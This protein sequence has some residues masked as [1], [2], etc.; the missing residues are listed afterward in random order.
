MLEEGKSVEEAVHES[1][2]TFILYDAPLSKPLKHLNDLGFFNFSKFL[3][4]TQGVLHKNIRRSP[5][6]VLMFAPLW[7]MMGAS[8]TID[9]L[10]TPF[11]FMEL[12][13]NRMQLNPLGFIRN[14][15]TEL[16][17]IKLLD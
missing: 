16:P 12:L 14:G 8:A 2:E 11:N 9:V 13:S 7:A 10:L 17:I 6:R 1:R 5:A 15:M 4:R 3:L